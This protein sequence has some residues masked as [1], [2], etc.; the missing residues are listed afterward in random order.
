MAIDDDKGVE[1]LDAA[2]SGDTKLHGG[3]KAQIEAM[4]GDLD[5][6]LDSFEATSTDR[7]DFL[8]ASEAEDRG[9]T[10][11]GSKPTDDEESEASDEASEETE[12][13]DDSEEGAEEAEGASSESEE[14]EAEA[15]EA[16][17]GDKASD[18]KRSDEKATERA[19]QRIP[20]TRFDEVNARRKAAEEELATLKAQLDAGEQA[21]E[22]QYDFVAAEEAYIDLVLA[23]KTKDAVIKRSEID[24]AKM[25]QWQRESLTQ[26]QESISTSQLKQDLAVI[27]K[28]AEASYDE[29]NPDSDNYSDDMVD[30]VQTFYQGYLTRQDLSPQ[31][32][33]R[34]ALDTTVRL[35]GLNPLGQEAPAAEPEQQP[36][37]VLKPKSDMRNKVKLA[38]KAPQDPGK[39]GA[40]GDAAGEERFDISNM[41]DD[42]LDAL[43]ES[44][45]K[46]LRGDVI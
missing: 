5:D 10:V 41:T 40:A 43:P 17:D 7:G 26:T 34:M 18:S 20:K 19:E 22:E 27:V 23:G 38:K 29:F 33:F 30:E 44:T 16:S 46:R 31:Q 25:A 15:E 42:E 12:A 28:E 13:S 35:Y 14:E 36:K 1:N 3:N 6:D 11:A 32:A 37:K 21:K 45:L 4:G 2:L 9:D 8:E 24:A 39:A